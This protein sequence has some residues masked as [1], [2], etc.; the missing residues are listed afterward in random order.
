VGGA[1][2]SGHVPPIRFAD[3][4]DTEIAYQVVGDTGPVFIATPGFA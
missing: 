3:A 1:V 4:G 2:V